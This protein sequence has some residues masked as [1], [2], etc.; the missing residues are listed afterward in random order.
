MA[1]KPG[2]LNVKA[3]TFEILA[4]VCSIALIGVMIGLLFWY[5]GK[6]IFHIGGDR[7]LNVIVSTL[8][9]LAKAALLSAVQKCISQ[10]NWVL[11]SGVSRRLYD[12][13]MI[14]EASRGPLGSF[15]VLKSRSLRGG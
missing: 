7:S 8:S 10:G 14:S 13:E 1:A 6:P 12:F 4:A 9:T 2:G 5:D 11:F 3:W 15:K